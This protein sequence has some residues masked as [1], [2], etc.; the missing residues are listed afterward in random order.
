MRLHRSVCQNTES[1]SRQR[2]GKSRFHMNPRVGMEFVSCELPW[3]ACM[4]KP[5]LIPAAAWTLLSPEEAGSYQGGGQED[6][7][8]AGGRERVGVGSIWHSAEFH[9]TSASF[10]KFTVMSCH[11]FSCKWCQTS[12]VEKH[13][14]ICLCLAYCLGLQDLTVSKQ[15]M[16]IYDTFPHLSIF[17]TI[18]NLKGVAY[19]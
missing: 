9:L 14:Y 15:N 5:E 6:T 1:E 3:S 4:P 8:S 2:S 11:S 12:L 7:E 13:G 17:T 19:F 10:V 16:F 18:F